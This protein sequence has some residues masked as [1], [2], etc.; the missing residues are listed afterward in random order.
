MLKFSIN[1]N[2]YE[3]VK[4]G[5]LSSVVMTCLS[6]PTDTELRFQFRIATDN[7]HQLE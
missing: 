2:S 6:N 1:I 4:P 7:Q 3:A 5:L